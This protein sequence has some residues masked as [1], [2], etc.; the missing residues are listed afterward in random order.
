MPKLALMAY[1]FCS[2]DTDWI[3]RRFS[4]RAVLNTPTEK[5]PLIVELGGRGGLTGGK[6]AE[7]YDAHQHS[8]ALR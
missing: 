4:N 7:R 3:E 2:A 1:Q 8:E 5:D 6:A